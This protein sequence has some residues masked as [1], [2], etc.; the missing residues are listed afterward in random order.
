MACKVLDLVGEYALSSSSGQKLYEILFLSLRDG[1]SVEV[2]F[3]GVLAV[4][5]AFLNAAVGQLLKDFEAEFLK[6]HLD[7]KNLNAASET[8][9]EHVIRNAKRYYSDDTYKDAVDSVSAEYVASV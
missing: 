8:A 9:L 5:S 7:F 4:A 1:S 2:D 3:D 6:S